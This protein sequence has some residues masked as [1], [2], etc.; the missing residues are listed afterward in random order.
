MT[1]QKN[2]RIAKLIVGGEGGVGKTTLIH[3]Y[4]E[5]EFLEGK[6]TIGSDFRV[7]EISNGKRLILQIWDLGGQERFQFIHPDYCRGAEFGFLC[8]A[9]NDINSFMNLDKW[10]EMFVTNAPGIKILLLGLKCDLQPSINESDIQKFVKEKQLLGYF[11]TS[12]KDNF[13][14]DEAFQALLNL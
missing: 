5:G 8:F 11:A 14:I 7:K 12:S 13:G 10:H 2:A 3:R 4:I 1:A 6:I 9:I